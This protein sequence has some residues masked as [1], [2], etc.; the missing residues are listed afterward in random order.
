MIMTDRRKDIAELVR[1]SSPTGAAVHTPAIMGEADAER[2]KKRRRAL[3]KLLARRSEDDT[4]T[5][6]KRL[7]KAD[8]ADAGRYV[9]RLLL[10]AEQL[11]A[12]WHLVARPGMP[13]DLDAN[14][15]LTV[16]YSRT[17]FDWTPDPGYVVIT[18]EQIKGVG[19]L[20]PKN[21]LVLFLDSPILQSRYAAALAAGATS[22]YGEYK[23]HMTLCYL[24]AEYDPQ[25]GGY[26]ADQ[27]ERPAMPLVFDRELSSP[28]GVDVFE[29]VKAPDWYQQARGVTKEQPVHVTV[30][31]PPMPAPVIHTHVNVEAQ[32]RAG[33]AKITRGPDGQSRVEFTDEP[34]APT[35]HQG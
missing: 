13:Y 9:G 24:G 21:A 30:N 12:W 10:N 4:L 22:D 8:D 32:K 7:T 1:K 3:A 26:Q 23:P 33:A 20:G 29:A 35:H 14:P 5:L 25:L 17:E 18:P 28:R 16:V 31:M 2:K 11:T 6:E 15:H 34:A 19:L 27:I